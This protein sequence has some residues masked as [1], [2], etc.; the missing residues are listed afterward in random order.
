MGY[1]I[2][3]LTSQYDPKDDPVITYV[4]QQVDRNKAYAP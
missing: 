1:H 4:F 3:D 2:R